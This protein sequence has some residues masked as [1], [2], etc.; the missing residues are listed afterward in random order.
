MHGCAHVVNSTC[1]NTYGSFTCTCLLGYELN[2]EGNAC[3]D[4]DEC[5]GP[6]N[7]CARGTSKCFNTEASFECMCDEG[8]LT[9][10]EVELMGN[11][12]L[13]HVEN[14]VFKEQDDG[15]RILFPTKG[16]GT[17]CVEVDECMAHTCVSYAEECLESNRTADVC[18][19]LT[20]WV[21]N[22]SNSP[23]ADGSS[24]EDDS[25]EGS[26]TDVDVL[27]SAGGEFSSP[28]AS[29]EQQH[30]G[31]NV[32]PYQAT[33]VR[34][35]PSAQIESSTLPEPHSQ[36]AGRLPDGYGTK[37]PRRATADVFNGTAPTNGSNGTNQTFDVPVSV[38]PVR[39]R[40]E[41][42]LLRR[43]LCGEHSQC[44]N[45]IGSYQVRACVHVDS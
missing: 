14:L 29:L 43:P 15:L 6:R 3:V 34:E 4:I 28:K 33:R 38:T 40:E 16:S 17:L 12:S 1:T 31:R 5:A 41:G 39:R 37:Y 8:F 19:S 22:A 30:A 44:F 21:A 25:D 23:G 13:S 35:L 26:N 18:A 7:N 2:K 11:C 36:G 9:P 20:W 32:D 10:E 27:R 45:S 42:M 24:D